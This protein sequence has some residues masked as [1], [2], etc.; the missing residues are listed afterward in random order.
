VHEETNVGVQ[1]TPSNIRRY[2]KKIVVM[3]PDHFPLLLLLCDDL[4]KVSVD[5]LVLL[6]EFGAA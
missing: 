1:V 6:P 2:Q 3:D 5:L 4:G